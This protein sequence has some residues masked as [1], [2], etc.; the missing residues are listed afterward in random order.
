M[1]LAEWLPSSGLQFDIFLLVM[2]VLALVVLA[3]YF[4]HRE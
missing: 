4:R 1:Y 3:R 2:C